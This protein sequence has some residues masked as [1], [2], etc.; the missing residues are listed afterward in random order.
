MIYKKKKRTQCECV[1]NQIFLFSCYNSFHS[2]YL[3]VCS[4]LVS[5][6]ALNTITNYCYTSSIS[7][8]QNKQTHTHVGD[9]IWGCRERKKEKKS[10]EMMMMRLHQ[11][12]IPSKNPSSQSAIIP[13]SR[14]KQ[15]QR[16]VAHEPAH[17]S[18]GVT[19]LIAIII[20][21]IIIIMIK[22]TNEQDT[23]N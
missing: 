12:P 5:E 13:N 7:C 2:Y 18:E 19:T 15:R 10:E 11:R 6:G 14:E 17:Q 3:E 23:I 22:W 16:W 8:E 20:I 4:G 1:F 9:R 21:I